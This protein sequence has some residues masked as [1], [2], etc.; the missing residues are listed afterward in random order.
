MN[1]ETEVRLVGGLAFLFVL[2]SLWMG[3]VK[4][5]GLPGGYPNPVLALELVK[6]GADID[7]INQAE[8]GKA[9]AFIRGSI[10]KDFGYIFVYT[11]FFV[12]FSLL[13][14]R[15]NFSW[16]KG[17]GWIA[18][19]CVTVAAVLDL[20]ENRGMLKAIAG[21]VSD[22]LANCIR[23]PSLAKWAFLFIFSLLA[24]LLLV[25]R[26]DLFAIP[27]LFFLV[28]ALLGLSGV[29]MNLLQPRFYWMFPAALLSLGLAV[30]FLA[31]TLTFWPEKLLNKSPSFI[32]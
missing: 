14:S 17:A 27:A 10:F 16:A 30:I 31:I 20:V 13:L 5:Q 9:R 4:I 22:S 2:Y 32:A 8:G 23:Y 28:A 19:A 26:R 25:S 6:N 3:Q 15:M 11:L 18:A 29:I 1:I 7:A 21:D 24:G 12:S